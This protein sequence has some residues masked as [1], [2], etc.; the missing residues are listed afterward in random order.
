MVAFNTILTQTYFDNTVLQYLIALG[1]IAAGYIVGKIAY[2]VIKNILIKF[3]E[4][5]ETKFDDILINSIHGPLVFL[6][7]VISFNIAYRTLLLNEGLLTFFERIT[8]VLVIVNIVWF[9]IKFL[10]EMIIHYLEPLAAKTTSDL[11]DHLVPIL[12]R[13]VKIILIIIAGIMILDDFGYNVNSILAGLGIGGLAF[14]FAAKDVLANMFG[15]ITI[16]ADKPFKIGQRIRID[17]YDGV[18]EEVGLRSTKIRTLDKTEVI[19][20]NLKFSDQII[21]NVTREPARKIKCVLGVVYDTPTKKLE[22]AIEIVKEVIEK[23]KLT[24][25]NYHVFFD[26]FGAYSL[27]IKVMYYVNSKDGEVIFKTQNEINFEIKRRFEQ[28]R[29]E[30][31]FPTQTIE[32]KK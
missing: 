11:D 14:A 24:T 28:Y 17:K 3:T 25:K 7:F 19:I 29:I 18:V 30:F 31:A 5:T 32:M 23:H 16:I 21:E 9:L 6:L 2:Y 13:V 10:D 27:N 15:G 12:R 26:E 22:Q 1:I 20:P 4:K 8:S